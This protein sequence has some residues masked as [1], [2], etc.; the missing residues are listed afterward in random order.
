MLSYCSSVFFR[1]F[2]MCI[3][4]DDDEDETPPFIF[5]HNVLIIRYNKFLTGF[6]TLHFASRFSGRRM[7]RPACSLSGLF[8]IRGDFVV[9]AGIE[10]TAYS[11]IVCLD[12]MFCF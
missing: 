6:R 12:T 9:Q 3:T 10:P 2:R 1:F 5:I 7:M 11:Y 8:T 4:A